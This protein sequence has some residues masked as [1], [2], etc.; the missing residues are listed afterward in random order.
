MGIT[1]LS[2][3]VQGGIIGAIIAGAFTALGWIISSRTRQKPPIVR[4]EPAIQL[5]PGRFEQ[6]GIVPL[7]E[8]APLLVVI[9]FFGLL[10]RWIRK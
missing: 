1:S 10:W 7:R 3:D 9:V 2:P 4:V 6:K 5:P 8:L